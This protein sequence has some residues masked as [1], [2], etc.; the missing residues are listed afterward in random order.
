MVDFKALLEKQQ[1]E[2]GYCALSP[3]FFAKPIKGFRTNCITG[4]KEEVSLKY[5]FETRP[6]GRT[7]F[8]LFGG[9]TGYESFTIDE[10]LDLDMCF[11]KGWY[12][13][14]GTKGRWDSLFIPAEEMVSAF[15]SH[16]KEEMEFY[17][18]SRTIPDYLVRIALA[19]S[20]IEPNA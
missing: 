13:C 14:A 4:H 19:L 20:R 10:Y 2:R 3:D 17:R 7:I 9:V 16:T 5:L 6:D 8:T 18:D 1:E 11:S 12:A 15:E